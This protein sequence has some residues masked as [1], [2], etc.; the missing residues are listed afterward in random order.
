[1]KKSLLPLL[2]ALTLTI[3][4]ATAQTKPTARPGHDREQQQSSPEEQASR[5]SE[6]MTKELDLNAEQ[7]ARIKQIMLTR[8][9]EMHGQRG[10][11]KGQEGAS[12][13]QKGEQMQANRAKYDAQFKEV[14]T[15]EQYTKYTATES[16]H[17]EHGG[18]PEG[19]L[20]AKPG[21]VKAKTKDS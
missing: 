19:K 18:K 9:Q 5:Q 7:S 11:G 16:K 6:R 17:K 1:M 21:K 10:Q 8:D 3:G 12:R 15:A 20:K 14:L 4:T 2:A 13:E